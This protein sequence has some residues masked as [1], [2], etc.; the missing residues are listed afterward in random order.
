MH[1][2]KT[3]MH[4][5]VSDIHTHLHTFI[6]LYLYGWCTCPDWKTCIYLSVYPRPYNDCSLG[7]K[8]YKRNKPPGYVM[9]DMRR[10]YGWRNTRAIQWQKTQC[11]QIVF[12]LKIWRWCW[13]NM[14]TKMGFTESYL[15]LSDKMYTKMDFT[16]K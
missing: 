12:H 16:G 10:C 14:Y 4:I 11:K 3:C 15:I 9:S 8:S 1:I 2:H 5:C 6:S 13:E 7:R